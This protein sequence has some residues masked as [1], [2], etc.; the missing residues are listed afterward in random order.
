MSAGFLQPVHPGCRPQTVVAKNRLKMKMNVFL[1]F[2][3]IFF[4]HQTTETTA[5]CPQRSFVWTNFFFWSPVRSLKLPTKR[6]NG[7]GF[8][9]VIWRL[10]SKKKQFC[11][12]VLKGGHCDQISVAPEL[13]AIATLPSKTLGRA[14]FRLVCMFEL[15]SKTK[16]RPQASNFWFEQERRCTNS[17]PS[18]VSAM[19]RM[20]NVHEV[21]WGRSNESHTHQAFPDSP[22]PL[23]PRWADP[24]RVC[25]FFKIRSLTQIPASGRT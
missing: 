18:L 13:R 25:F 5:S 16:S 22:V 14:R 10:P 11:T 17:Q 24:A 12:G 2:K 21:P 6:K 20:R 19:V 8:L 7:C 15:N 23:G 1:N 9:F 4:C 3:P